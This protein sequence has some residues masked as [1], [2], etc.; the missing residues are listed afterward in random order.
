MENV[1]D[2]KAFSFQFSDFS[3]VLQ[4]NKGGATGTTEMLL[5]AYN[6]YRYVALHDGGQPITI[7]TFGRNFN[8]IRR[9]II[10]LAI[11]SQVFSRRTKL[12]GLPNLAEC[13]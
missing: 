5:N 12:Q 10:I 7:I 6:I 1:R 13:N 8:F 9:M 2:A 3:L 11:K 4:I